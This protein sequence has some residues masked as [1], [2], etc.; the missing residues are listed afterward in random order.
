MKFRDALGNETS[1]STKTITL[2]AS[3]PTQPELVS[4]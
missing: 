1:N 4:P 3:L 2:D